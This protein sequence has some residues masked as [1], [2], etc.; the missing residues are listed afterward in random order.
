[1]DGKTTRRLHRQCRDGCPKH[2]P[3]VGTSKHGTTSNACEEQLKVVIFR[4]YM[5]GNG[6]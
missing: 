5:Y 6:L 4:E 2:I 3:M 1:M